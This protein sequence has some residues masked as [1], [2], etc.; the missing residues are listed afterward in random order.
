MR[1]TNLIGEMARNGD[2]DLTEEH[3]VEK[4]LRSMPKRYAQIINSIKMLLDFE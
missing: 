1:L 3:A 4:F 2:T